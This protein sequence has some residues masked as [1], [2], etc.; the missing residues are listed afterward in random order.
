MDQILTWEEQA[1]GLSLL[2]EAKADVEPN[3]T[4]NSKI[5]LWQG[6]LTVLEIDA[7]VNAANSRLAGGGGGKIKNSL[8]TFNQESSLAQQ[9]HSSNM[10]DEADTNRV[11]PFYFNS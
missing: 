3:C 6:D 5:S 8:P 10:Y 7:I 1:K 11:Q 2:G 9:L 4:L